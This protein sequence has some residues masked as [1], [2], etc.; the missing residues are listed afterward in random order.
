MTKKGQ[1]TLFIVIGLILL[2]GISIYLYATS[3]AAI[4]PVEAERIKMAEVPTEVQ[5]L[6]EFITDCLKVTARQ[7][8]QLIGERGGYIEPK[9][10]YHPYEPTEGSAVQ[11]A[12]NSKLKVPYWWHLSSKNNCAGDCEFKSERPSLQSI[13]TQMDEYIRKELPNCLGRFENFAKQNMIV[14]P[15][16]DIKPDTQ[17]TKGNVVVVLNYPVE[18]VLSGTKFNLKDY[19]AELQVPFYEIYILA[20]NITE[21]EAKYSFLE[22]GTRNLI[23]IF[24]RLD[25]NALP[26]VSDMEFG[27]GTGTFWTKFEVKDKISQ[28]LTSYIPLL[29]V[30]N[31]KNYRWLPA[32]AGKDKQFYEV[33][34]NRGFTVPVLEPH[35]SLEAKFAYLPWWRPYFDLNC[36]GQL[37]QS[38]GIS[39]TWGFMFGMRRYNF[40][41][42]LSY[43]VL[44]D[45]KS[46]DAYGGE[47]YSFRFF[48][49]AN[50]RNNM[51]I[52]AGQPELQLTKL[53]DTRSMMCLPE[54]RTSGEITVNASTSAG[55]PVDG[56]EI[57][58][59]C[60][61]ESCGVGTTVNGKLV[62]KLPRCLGGV[63]SATHNDYPSAIKPLD[64]IGSSSDSVKLVMS[65][66]YTV[67]F[68]VKKWLVK[69]ETATGSWELDPTQ[70]VNQGPKENTIIMLE[71]KQMEFEPQVTV[72]GDVCGSPVNKAKIPCGNPP[73]DN[74]KN[75]TIYAGDY[76]VTIYS[77]Y[78]PSPDLVIPAETR[79]YDRGPFK[80][81]GRY[82]VPEARFNNDDKQMMS[83]SAEYDWTV[84]EEQLKG[85]KTIEFTYFNFAL[86]KVPIEQRKIE[87]LDVLGEFS[88]YSESYTDLLTPVIR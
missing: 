64:I 62:A 85:A 59:R 35:R 73:T 77:F 10:S 12:P 44:V 18:A 54:Q 42:D 55:V 11:F 70:V 41:Y 80:K 7:G 50:M 78:Y 71:R 58:Y 29:K 65:T 52:A 72:F 81:R 20:T 88:S 28:M 53:I 47:G 16:G 24:G 87:D 3:R 34:Y 67:D 36:N 37:C 66:P 31:T 57:I 6:D 75:V 83:G 68:E 79:H 43:P 63:V 86:D 40:A 21:I 23:D 8:L 32:P 30:M 51:P 27:F 39:N 2:V 1:L 82:T 74:S 60:G 25:A 45:I 17:I 5:P 49:E 26:P 84:T 13:K 38:E 4:A 9:Q 46:P 61:K 14:T 33:L 48:L 22:L 56:A 15:A 76:H 19:A 69:K